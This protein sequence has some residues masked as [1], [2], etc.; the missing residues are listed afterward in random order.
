MKKALCAVALFLCMSQVGFSQDKGTYRQALNKMMDVS[1]T[2]ASYQVMIKQMLASYKAQQ[3]D[4]S[5]KLMADL[6]KTLTEFSLSKLVD[7]LVPIYQQH[8]SEKDLN[9]IIAFYES[10]AGKKYAEKVP[11]LIRESMAAGQAWG[12]ELGAEVARKLQEEAGEEEEEED[13]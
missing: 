7:R 10:P 4:A 3:P 8:L 1:G 11:L 6:E 9:G 5:E 2:T 12:A 13:F